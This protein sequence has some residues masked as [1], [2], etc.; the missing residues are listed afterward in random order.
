MSK[1]RAREKLLWTGDV[2][3]DTGDTVEMSQGSKQTN[4]QPTEPLVGAAFFWCPVRLVSVVPPGRELPQC[5]L[6]EEIQV[7]A[8]CPL[9][10]QESL[11]LRLWEDF[12]F[13]SSWREK[14]EKKHT[15]FLARQE[16]VCVYRLGPTPDTVGYFMMVCVHP[17]SHP[18]QKSS[19]PGESSTFCGENAL[20][21]G[22]GWCWAEAGLVLPC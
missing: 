5:W 18:A 13:H 9:R 16:V 10:K 21:V 17:V 2:T 3:G 19:A 1:A 20:E 12:T 15:L 4:P 22:R 6:G 11:S 14:R 7:F 8:L